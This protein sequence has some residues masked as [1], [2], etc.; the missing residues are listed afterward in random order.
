VKGFLSDTTLALLEER[1][2]LGSLQPV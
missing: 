1:E 2:V